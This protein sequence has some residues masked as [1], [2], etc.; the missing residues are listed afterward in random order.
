MTRGAAGV[1]AAGLGAGCFGGRA[2]RKLEGHY[3]LSTPGT[4]WSPVKPGSADHA[5]FN[6]DLDAS[7]YADSNCGNR[8]VDGTLDA[9]ST[10]LTTGV[11]TG[12]PLRDEHLTL[13]NRDALLRVSDGGIDGVAMRIG[14]VVMNKD[15]CTYDLV[16][17]APPDH[18][19]AGWPAF[20]ATFASL[21]TRSGAQK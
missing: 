18:F 10:H 6:A 7:I 11:T 2:A 17:V 20:Q 1:L 16:Y 4:G 15:S 8:F 5:W 19:D 21:A 9:V 12:A 14:S 13:A 3:D